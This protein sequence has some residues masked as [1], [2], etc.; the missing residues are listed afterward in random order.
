MPEG[1]GSVLD[2]GCLMFISNMGSGTKHD[3]RKVPVITVVGL[4]GTLETGRA[5]DYL[6]AGDDHRELCSLFLG[7]WTGW[8]CTSNTAAMRGF[9]WSASDNDAAS[10]TASAL[11]QA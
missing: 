3:N 2:H 11:R 10:L 8:A 6:K 5:L 9:N 1:D 7:S 4:G